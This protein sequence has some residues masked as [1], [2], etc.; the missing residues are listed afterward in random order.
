MG[1]TTGEYAAGRGG[2][3]FGRRK[4]VNRAGVGLGNGT[5]KYGD[6]TGEL[7]DVKRG[8]VGMNRLGAE[9]VRS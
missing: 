5:V 2:K 9:T 8:M 4:K 1:K 7:G 3:G 6:R